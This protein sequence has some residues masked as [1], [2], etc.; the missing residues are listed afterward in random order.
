MRADDFDVL[1]L[2]L[3]QSAEAV[4][5]FHVERADDEEAV[6]EYQ[7]VDRGNGAC[8]GVLDGQHAVGDL[9][10][11][12]RFKNVVKGGVFAK[13][14]FGKELERRLVGIRALDALIGYGDVL[15]AE[16]VRRVHYLRSQ[17]RSAVHEVVLQRA[18]KLHDVSV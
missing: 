16:S 4:V 1:K 18:R 3:A 8:R 13:L 5:D 6:P 11:L 14:C 9:A 17:R 15:R 10:A 7:V 2:R 12:Y